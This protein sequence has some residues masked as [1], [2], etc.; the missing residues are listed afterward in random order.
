MR[1]FSL[2]TI[3]SL[4]FLSGIKAPAFP[5]KDTVSYLPGRI[6]VQLEDPDSFIEKQNQLESNNKSKHTES[7][8]FD[9]VSTENPASIL[10]R[11][12]NSHGVQDKTPVFRSN[13]PD[14]AKAIRQPGNHSHRL[15]ELTEAF[16]RTFFIRYTSGEDPITLSR[17]IRELPG[18]AY[19][20]PHYVRHTQ[21]TYI[22]ND[23]LYGEDGQN[24]FV[25]QNFHR[26]WDVTHGSED[27]VISI[28]DS[29]VYYDHP[30]LANKLWRNPEPGRASEFF[31]PAGWEIENDTIGWNFWESGDV[32]EGEDPVQNANPV[33]TY[34]THG[35]H[36]AGTAAADTDNEIGIAGTG[37][38]SK[39]MPVRAGGTEDYPGQIAYGYHGII[40]SALNDADIINCSF[41]GPGFSEFGKQAVDFA[42]ESGS[43]VIAAAG[44]EGNDVPF[45]PAAYENAIAVGSVTSAVSYQISAF[46]NYGFF[47]DVFASG[48]RLLSTTFDFDDHAEEWTP[49]YETNTG[50]S[51]AAPVV[52]GLAALI[53]AENPDW[54]PGRIASQIRS[55]A[56][57]ID[58]MNTEAR[59]DHRLGKGMIDAYSSLVDIKPG[60]QILDA[61]FENEDGDKISMGESGTITLRAVNHGQAT[62]E[63]SFELDVLTPDIVALTPEI[64]TGQVNTQDTFHVQLDIEISAD[65]QT[66]ETP[67]FRLDFKDNTQDYTDFH[68][69]KYENLFYDM[70]DANTIRASISSDGTI[71]FI[72][73]LTSSG[74]VGFIP[75]DYENIL[76]EGGLMIAADRYA[77]GTSE[78]SPVVI[79][80]V[81]DS[82]NI[83]RHFKP[84]ENVRFSR[85]ELHTGENRVSGNAVF[86]SAEHPEADDLFIELYSYALSRERLE[87]SFYIQF[88]I[89]NDG[90]ATYDDMYVGLFNDW[91][92]LNFDSNYTRFIREDSLVYA[93]DQSG[94][95]YV[96]VGHM[97]PVSSALA[98]DNNSPMTLDKAETRQ[99]SL[100]F[101]INYNEG[102]SDFDGFTDDEK[103]LALTA[104]TEQVYVDNADISIVTGSGPYTL[105]PQ[106]TIEVG[107]VYAWG[108]TDVEMRLQ[109]ERARNHH[110]YGTSAED[111]ARHGEELPDH[112]ALSQ[113]YPN[114]FNSTTMIEYYL[115]ETGHAELAVYNLLG[116]KVRT[117]VNGPVN[118]QHH[119]AH[120]DASGLASGI[121]IAVLRANNHTETIKM[122]LVK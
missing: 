50:T 84:V 20:E 41:G 92:I 33:G 63:L 68:M 96:A 55:N 80:Q 103:R 38:N 58:H 83:T 57:S 9:E 21:Q 69:F 62:N 61:I 3:L 39:F 44:N 10:E 52:S 82:T 70:L 32:F 94:P 67:L 110:V 24:Y 7:K 64:S 36:V 12:L 31:S 17:E 109:L 108:E 42:T 118:Q 106:E 78:P 35:T 34:S 102:D 53:K 59:Y 107:F 85:E 99:D 1:Y 28:V 13:L 14:H 122:N 29:G 104:G 113:N 117:L 18:V 23:S 90:T 81:R 77:A 79:N 97:G 98:I 26:A 51:M 65:Y 121:Y 45:F 46:S 88:E 116:Q 6:I 37:F 27:V 15:A 25:G 91:D 54:K 86:T 49:L 95:P 115:P 22:P 112:P 47:V 72:D 111:P 75:G 30:D 114:P 5:S 100:R 89:T 76:Y 16:K 43:L 73:A 19:A 74:G 56:A 4:L 11:H 2:I 40:Y 105:E 71:G 60:I 66:D 8:S 48:Q 119:V 101:G 87:R 120:F 93:Y